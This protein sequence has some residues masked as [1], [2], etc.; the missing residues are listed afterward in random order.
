MKPQSI[1]LG[2]F[3]FAIQ[4]TLYRRLKKLHNQ[5]VEYNKSAADNFKY[6]Q[7]AADNVEYN[8]FF[9]KRR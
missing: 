8:N 5:N 9:G 6:N 3:T 4:C 2:L 7:S 1:K